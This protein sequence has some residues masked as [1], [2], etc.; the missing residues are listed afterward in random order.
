MAN[1]E[2]FD[3]PI[4]DSIKRAWETPEEIT[5]RLFEKRELD[6]KNFTAK[7]EE[8]L[9]YALKRIEEMRSSSDRLPDTNEEKNK[10]TEDKKDAHY[11]DT[12]G[13]L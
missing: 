7:D 5:K 1:L 4:Q 10:K 8:N 13:Y 9:E 11:P 6:P 3:D 12:Q 2:G